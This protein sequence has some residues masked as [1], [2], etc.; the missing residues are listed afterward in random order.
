MILG[1]YPKRG[2]ILVK[3]YQL[4]PINTLNFDPKKVNHVNHPLSTLKEVKHSEIRSKASSP[5]REETLEVDSL[6]P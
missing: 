1:Y 6:P 3:L 2:S 4:E 5:W